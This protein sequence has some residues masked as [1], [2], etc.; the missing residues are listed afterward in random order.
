MYG[1]SP[2]RYGNSMDIIKT[3]KQG[4]TKP[5]TCMEC[6]Y[7]TSTRQ[8]LDTHVKI[9][10]SKTK[11]CQCNQCNRAFS[12]EVHLNEHT[13]LAHCMNTQVQINIPTTRTVL[14]HVNIIL[15]FRTLIFFN[16]LVNKFDMSS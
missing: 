12:K 10:H 8:H 3:H 16:R 13:Q 14:N 5:F 7:A 2:D 4:T 1:S 6:P 11:D 9:F 15:A